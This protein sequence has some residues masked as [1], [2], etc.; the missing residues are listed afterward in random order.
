MDL[1][2]LSM[3][4]K[5]DT[6]NNKRNRKLGHLRSKI[7]ARNK[8]AIRKFVPNTIHNFSSYELTKREQ[9]VLCYSL[10]QSVPSKID[11]RGLQVEFESF[12]QSVSHHLLHLTEDER[13]AFKTR[14]RVI[15]DQYSKVPIPRD[16]QQVIKGL[17]AN[18]SIVIL[19]QDK[20]RGVVIVD[21]SLY[22]EKANL[23]LDSNKFKKLNE[24]PTPRIEGK[25]QRALR[26]IK[27]D[28]E[29]KEYKQL[30]PQ[31]SRPARFYGTAKVHKV[32]QNG[33]PS[34]L[35][36]RP[37]VSNIGT[38]TYKTSKYLAKLLAPLATSEYTVD[39]TRSFIKELKRYT[40]TTNET[41][42]SFD[43]SSLF[44]NVPLDETIKIVLD[45]VY[46]H[47]E[48]KT[49]I[50]RKELKKLLDLC[51]KEV[52]FTFNGQTYIQ[53]DG[54]AMGSPLGPVLA[55]IFMVEL[56]S[57]LIPTLRD[58]I[59]LWRRYVDDTFAIVKSDQVEN[60]LSKLNS[61]HPNIAFTYELEMNN[62]ISFLD[63]TVAK[64]A[65]GHFETS[66]YRKPTNTDLYIH[67]LSYAPEPWKVGTLKTLIRRAH[68]I[69]STQ[70][71]VSNEL[72]HLLQVFTTING[73]PKRLVKSII[74]REQQFREQ[75]QTEPI[76]LEQ[77]SEPV[78]TQAEQPN[79][80]EELQDEEQQDED[81]P[82]PTNATPML[83]LPYAGQIGNEIVK[84]YRS[85]LDKFLPSNIQ[86]KIV[87]TSRKLSTFFPLKDKVADENKHD[88]VYDFN[89]GECSSRYI[90][91]T[92]RRYA[93]R[94][95][96]HLATD[97][98][99]HVYKHVANSGHIIGDE[100]F[101]IIG[102]NYGYYK[103]RKIAEAL[104][105][106]EKKPDLNVKS[107]SVKLKLF[108]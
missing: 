25:V 46:K 40:A 24:D 103:K 17:S 61:F 52:H 96:D 9:E 76:E 34:T 82:T 55:N 45:R 68:D 32:P 79:D 13:T 14:T 43:V 21:K 67:W 30:Y 11:K 48:V 91:E 75:H 5:R 60:V 23:L 20:G 28:L 4:H 3:K 15:Y 53:V 27:Q 73:Y 83:K 54:V 38:A 74:Q 69:C 2:T 105:I 71:A 104:H 59:S 88:I 97:K 16:D 72:K 42:I 41:L 7:P 80:P 107:E 33:D 78:P 102:Q 95:H 89:C 94:I 18:E 92:G 19:K 8:R 58:S 22:V 106:R 100:N 57:S 81:Q 66:V 35:P 93:K 77:P 101:K 87:Y 49:K 51:T 50:K 39:S 90:G 84:R 64:R 85:C 56:E 6:W 65:D 98:K 47:K 26:E 62:T 1:S 10:D 108:N 99:S 29:E 44:T 70:E 37:I 31:G 36:I 63:V 12:Y 86:P